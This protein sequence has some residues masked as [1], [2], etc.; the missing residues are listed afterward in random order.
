MDVLEHRGEGKVFNLGF[1]KTGTTSFEHAMRALGFRVAHGHWAYNY[2]FFLTAMAL[3]EEWDEVLRFTNLV[4]VFSD[5]P[6]GGGTNLYKVLEQRLPEATFVMTLR[7]AEIWYASFEKQIML[8]DR[9]PETALHSYRR[10]MYG[11]GYWFAKVFDIETLAGNR[12]R[13]IDR[14][15][16]YNDAVVD[17]FGRCNRPLTV[18]DFAAGDGWEKLCGAVGKPVPER[19]FP[20]MNKTNENWEQN[21]KDLI[22]RVESYLQTPIAGRLFGG[23]KAAIK[24]K[25]NT[26]GAAPPVS[27]IK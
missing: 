10:Y 24:T 9:D 1:S 19:P 22:E 21:R 8:F 5:G 25:A 16:R 27:A 15:N 11:S 12:D 2:T 26:D 13:I 6:W 18:L 17:Y 3:I 4:D 14:Y 20:R 7:P 23:A